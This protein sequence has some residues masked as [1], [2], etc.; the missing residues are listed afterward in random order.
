MA[1]LASADVPYKV[2]LM[3]PHL[4]VFLFLGSITTLG[5]FG[6]SFVLPMQKTAYSISA[7]MVFGL[8]CIGMPTLL[9]W[10]YDRRDKKKELKA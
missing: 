4:K 9:A 1:L 6:Y 5:L 7:L 3:N 8:G 10:W 2:V